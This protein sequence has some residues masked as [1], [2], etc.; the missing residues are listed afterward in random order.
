VI[1]THANKVSH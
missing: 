1:A